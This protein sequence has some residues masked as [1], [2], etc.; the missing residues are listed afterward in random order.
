MTIEG[1]RGVVGINVTDYKK[2]ATA[3]RN[4]APE[5]AKLMRK[6]LMTAGELVAEGT[7]R[8]VLGIPVTGTDEGIR[9]DIS[10]SVKVKVTGVRVMVTIGEGLDK[11]PFVMSGLL[12]RGGKGRGPWN[13]PLFGIEGT[14]YAENPHPYLQPA[15]DRVEP[16]VLAGISEALEEGLAVVVAEEGL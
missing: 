1:S 5:Q 14:S 10:R 9:T 15:F 7:R 3:L 12:E 2:L 4:V 8:N 6:R 11:Y 13:H 16:E